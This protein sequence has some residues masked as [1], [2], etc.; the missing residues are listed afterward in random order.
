MKKEKPT[1][2]MCKHCKTEIPYNAKVCPQ[3]R[4]KQGMGCLTKIILIF[5]ILGVIYALTPGED[6]SS[7]NSSKSVTEETTDNTTTKK[8]ATAKATTEKPVPTEYVSALKKAQI[9]VDEMHMSKKGL[10]E[11]LTSEYGEQFDKKA[12]KY[13]VKHV[14]ANWKKN[15]LAKAKDYQ[16]NMSMSKEAIRDQLTSDAGEKFTKQEDDYAIKHLD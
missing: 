16:E 5:V 13:A 11:Q 7:N 15:A 1:T 10:Y 3:C 14:K 12:A 8:S 9:Y 4:K 2:K 6:E